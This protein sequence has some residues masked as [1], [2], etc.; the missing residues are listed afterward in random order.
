[1]AAVLQAELERLRADLRLYPPGTTSPSRILEHASRTVREV[2]ARCLPMGIAI[3]MH[4]YPVCA[5]Q[6][7]PLPA[8]SIAAFKRRLLMNAIR[9]RGLLVANAGSERANGTRNA[10]AVTLHDDGVRVSG[11]CEYVSLASLADVVLFSAPLGDRTVVCAAD[12]RAAT[13][14]IGE[15]RFTGRMRLSDTRPLTFV[16]HCVPSGRFV[17]AA[18][19][20]ATS[21]MIDYQRCWFHLL[22]ADAYLARIELLRRQGPLASGREHLA[23]L[24]ETACLR[25]YASRLLDECRPRA[26]VEGLTRVTSLLKLRVSSMAQAMARLLVGEDA[27]ELGYMRQQ[28][29]ADERILAGLAAS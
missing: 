20:T 22:L 1:M 24:L 5:L 4:L 14:R 8:L 19:S 27:A 2:A 26:S 13:V 3:V 12:M 11:T 15:P 23:Q 18:D 10:L 7:A 28:P 29:T 25:E 16:D 9:A 21:C 17:L 6:C